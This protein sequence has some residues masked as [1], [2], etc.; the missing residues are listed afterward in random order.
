MVR[1]IREN[2]EARRSGLQ[3]VRTEAGTWKAALGK[4]WRGGGGE[5]NSK[6]N[7]LILL[8]YPKTSSDVMELG[9]L[10][11]GCECETA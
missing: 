8:N 9:G 1:Y 3:W 7:V 6:E 2:S 5:G 10:N 11:E 4:R